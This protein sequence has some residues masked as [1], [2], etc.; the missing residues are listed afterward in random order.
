MMPHLNACE[1][2]LGVDGR[3]IPIDRPLADRL[4][5][6]AHADGRLQ[7]SRTTMIDTHVLNVTA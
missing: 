7:P 2:L 5:L 6:Q 4:A 1:A 3:V